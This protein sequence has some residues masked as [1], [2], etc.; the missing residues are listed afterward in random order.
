MSINFPQDTS[1]QLTHTTFP[2]TITSNDN[3]TTLIG[4]TILLAVSGILRTHPGRRGSGPGRWAGRPPRHGP[5]PPSG[6]ASSP[7]L[8]DA[9]TST[10]PAR[11][12]CAHTPTGGVGHTV[13][14]AKKSFIR[15][16]LFIPA[17]MVTMGLENGTIIALQG[18]EREGHVP[19]QL[20][21]AATGRPDAAPGGRDTGTSPSR[22]HSGGCG[23]PARR[24]RPSGT[25]RA[26]LSEGGE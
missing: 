24:A 26:P 22:P 9:A 13:S 7:A 8:D 23:E 19:P 11:A 16:L 15:R 25:T 21:P 18:G 17:G 1:T 20:P 4:C 14:P 3:Y 2:F 12:H 10:A 5:A 6:C